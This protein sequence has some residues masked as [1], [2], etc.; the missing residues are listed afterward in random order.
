MYCNDK[1]LIK[2]ESELTMEINE[3]L[4]RKYIYHNQLLRLYNE[5][6]IEIYLEDYHYDEELKKYTDYVLKKSQK[7]TEIEQELL[8]NK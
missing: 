2:K 5:G 4:L 8:K 3:E 6:L 1:Y 7:I